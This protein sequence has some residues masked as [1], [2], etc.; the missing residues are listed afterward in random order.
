MITE[1]ALKKLRV[2]PVSKQF[3]FDRGNPVDRYYMEKFLAANQELIQ[4][5]VLEIAESTYTM[6]F[7]GARVAKA[8]ILHATDDNPQ[9]DMVGDLATGAGIC[10]NI[11]DCFIL[12]QTLLCIYDVR[13]ALSNAVKV[14]KPGGH[15][16]LTVPGITQISRYDM[17]RWGQYWSFTDLAVRKLCEQ[18][19]PG[20][21]I[22]VRTYGNV[23][24]AACF[25]YGLAAEEM[26]HQDLDYHDPDYQLLIAAVVRKP[27]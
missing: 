18:A 6:R 20:G 26:S 27:R 23:K 11:V 3:G 17:D 13:A 10:E 5:D 14:L 21:E 25:L 12:T 19:A 22:S 24:A 4:G 1:L 2:T 16:L 9:A 7:G 8:M 15:L